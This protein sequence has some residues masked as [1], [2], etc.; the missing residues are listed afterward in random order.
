MS[1]VINHNM[2]A[3]HA[4]RNLQQA[5]GNLGTSTRRLSSG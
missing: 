1:L 5:Y 4:S 2:M 3:M